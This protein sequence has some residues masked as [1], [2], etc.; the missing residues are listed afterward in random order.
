LVV[1]AACAV[2]RSFDRRRVFVTAGCHVVRCTCGHLYVSPRPVVAPNGAGSATIW[3]D[4]RAEVVARS[5]ER[6]GHAG[7]LLEISA[8]SSDLATA[9]ERR[10][11]ET[12]TLGLDKHAVEWATANDRD[13][14]HHGSLDVLDHGDEFFDCVALV[15]ALGQAEQPRTALIEVFRVLRLG[16]VLVVTTPDAGSPLARAMGRRW[17]GL[18]QAPRQLHFFTRDGLRQLLLS[19]GFVTLDV[20]RLPAVTPARLVSDLCISARKAGVGARERD[21]ESAGVVARLSAWLRRT[22]SGSPALP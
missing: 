7:R 12:W 14:V 21:T 3:P 10:G 11:W 13:R 17:P 2:C 6:S 22:P 16:G 18:R 8:G 5:I 9:M 20:A 15:D 4:E 1:D 19:T